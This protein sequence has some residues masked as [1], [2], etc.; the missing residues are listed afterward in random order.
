MTLAREFRLR[1]IG[2]ASAGAIAAVIAAAAEFRRQNDQLAAIDGLLRSPID[3][4]TT[5]GFMTS[6]LIPARRGRPALRVLLAL[7]K[8]GR[9]P[10]RRAVAA[11]RHVIV[12][13]WWWSVALVALAC[14][15]TWL[16]MRSDDA[17]VA[18]TVS[19]LALVWLVALVLAVLVPVLLVARAT[20][21]VLSAPDHGFGLCSG[22]SD[23]SLALTDWLHHTIQEVA[24]LPHSRPLTFADLQSR[25]IDLVMIATDVGRAEPV[26][27][28]SSDYWYDPKE[29]ERLL[30]AAVIERLCS[31]R[32]GSGAGEL[33]QLPVNELPVLV[34]VRMSMSLPLLLEA[35]PLYRVGA[36]GRPSRKRRTW[37]LDG[38]VTSNFPIHFFDEWLPRRP[39]FG[40]D[41]RPFPAGHE[42]DP[43]ERVKLPG[44]DEL[45]SRWTPIDGLVPLLQQIVDAAQNWRD[46]AQ[47]D[48]PGFRD[49]V[50]QIRL[51]PGEGGLHLDMDSDTLN[52][53][54]AAGKE[55]GRQLVDRFSD[56]GFRVHRRARYATLL[57]AL[58]DRLEVL[59]D[60]WGG[61]R[62]EFGRWLAHSFATAARSEDEPAPEP[63]RDQLVMRIVPRV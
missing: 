20:R 15:T 63:E 14:A 1:G 47:A 11:L 52:T 39:T 58:K 36:D 53:L 16:V 17:P 3:D 42:G 38:G 19:L 6:L 25:G 56:D 23:D 48:L 9:P 21:R 43:P 45:P 30:P 7:L 62:Y 29:L 50:C 8:Q 37:L 22:R 40:L 31:R 54:V 57:G 24:D 61:L 34:A 49:R 41:L 2:G 10:W 18:M 26:R 4:L 35:V 27:L 12:S 46:T 5:P 51:G 44:P 33:Q 60:P 59:A 13:R 28:P 55:A 32:S